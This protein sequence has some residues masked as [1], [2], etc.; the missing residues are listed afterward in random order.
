V[1]D[2]SIAF[3]GAGNMAHALISG[4]IDAGRDPQ[5][6]HAS[7]PDEGQRNNIRALGVRVFENNNAA[8]EGADI[9]LLAVKPQAA[10]SVVQALELRHSQL[11][12]SICAGVAVRHL[13][14]WTQATQPIVR[15]MPNT[16]ALLRAGITALCANEQVSDAQRS[17][18]QMLLSAV[19]RVVWVNEEADLDAITAV[20]GSG[21]AYFFYLMDA[22]I[23]AGVRLGLPADLA[24]TLTVETALG[25]A[26]MATETKT[27]PGILRANVTS[28][29]GTTEAA[30]KSLDE[31]H[32]HEHVVSALREAALRAR[33]L[34]EEL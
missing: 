4:L 34:A 7:D 33:T 2:P 27:P 26:R 12:I 20:S 6:L 29:G 22:M 8:L 31:A 24:A 13:R 28:P 14:E 15:C 25:A 3:I 11:L 32:T 9:V 1:S 21:P 19:G 5:G 17:Q 18:A 30:L 10:R 16:P 23:D